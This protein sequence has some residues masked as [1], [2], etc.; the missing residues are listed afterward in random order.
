[1]HI[2]LP[3]RG[4]RRRSKPKLERRELGLHR[5]FLLSS[6]RLTDEMKIIPLS[7]RF[8]DV[9]AFTVLPNIALLTCNAM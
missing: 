7:L 2:G 4:W 3:L 8:C 6:A 9:V 1:M 5:R